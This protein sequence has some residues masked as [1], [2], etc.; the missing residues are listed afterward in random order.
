[1]AVRIAYVCYWDA[2]RTDGVSEKIEVQSSAWRARGN[3]VEVFCLS[4]T[5]PAP[6]RPVFDGPI[7]AFDGAAQRIAETVKLERAVGRYAPGCVYLRYDLFVPL[8]VRT[9]RS[10]TCAVEI[11]SVPDELRQR[12][13]PA[14][15]RYA[16]ISQAITLRGAAGFVFVSHEIA[17]R[18]GSTGAKTPCVVIANGAGAVPAR[19]VPAPANARPKI[20]FLAGSRNHWH[21][22]DKLLWLAGQMREADFD[23]VGLGPA[24]LGGT[25]TENVTAHGP[26]APSSCRPILDNADVAF[27]SLALHRINMSEASPLKVR[28]SLLHGLP[29]VIGYD[30]TDFLAE[31]P[32]YIL[33]LPN[34]ESNVRD[35]LA[36]IRSFVQRSRGRR[37][38][39]EIAVA[40][41]GA[42]AKEVARLEFLE[43]L[44]RGGA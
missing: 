15:R 25:P 37:V 31:T 5:A 23:I 4:P 34:T 35:H 44:L 6:Q 39:H 20:V 13:G 2:Y 22:I 32:W 12:L 28:A 30:D 7:F 17:D 40:R 26:L 33:K 42:A 3:E 1:M 18:W 27:G 16:D 8:L 24:E 14:G 19:R 10:A 36:D 38:P 41:V 9:M 21:G 43:R 11:N 29:V